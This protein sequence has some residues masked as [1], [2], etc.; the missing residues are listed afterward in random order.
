[1]GDDGEE[2][3]TVTNSLKMRGVGVG[4]AAALVLGSAADGAAQLVVYPAKGQTP[5]QQSRDQGEGQGW[6]KTNTGVDPVAL[7]SQP[8]A[9]PSQPRGGRLKGAA[10][11]AAIGAAGGA[12]AG[13]AGKGAGAGAAAGAVAGGI[14]QR[15]ERRAQ[16]SAAVTADRQKQGAMEQYNKAYAA[17]LEGRGYTVK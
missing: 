6:A 5:E 2:E 1:M 16:E 3:P 9:P 13:D 15:R 12:A 11:G 7:A 17:C 8:S 4:L 10:G 14:K